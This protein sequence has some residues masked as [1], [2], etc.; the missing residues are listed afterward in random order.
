MGAEGG[1]AAVRLILDDW[2]VSVVMGGCQGGGNYVGT[3][4]TADGIAEDGG[5]GADPSVMVWG[6]PTG[7]SSV[8]R[9]SLKRSGIAFDSI[10]PQLSLV[11]TS[12]VDCRV[13]AL[14]DMLSASGALPGTCMTNGSMANRGRCKP[15]CPTA[16]LSTVEATCELGQFVWNSTCA[17]SSCDATDPTLASPCKNDGKCWIYDVARR[18]DH[19]SIWVTDPVVSSEQVACE[20]GSDWVGTYCEIPAV[21]QTILG[22]PRCQN[23]GVCS[24]KAQAAGDQLSRDFSCACAPGWGGSTCE[25]RTHAYHHLLTTPSRIPLVLLGIS[26]LCALVVV[27]PIAVRRHRRRLQQ[28]SPVWQGQAAYTDLGDGIDTDQSFLDSASIST[29][30]LAHDGSTSRL[31]CGRSSQ[32]WLQASFGCALGVASLLAGG[33]LCLALAADER[34]LPFVL[35]C[36]A[37]TYIATTITTIYMGY[38]TLA[39]IAEMEGNHVQHDWWSSHRVSVALLLLL[40]ANRIE[41]LCAV[42]QISTCGR[43]GGRPC[44]PF[45]PPHV[46]FLWS[47]GCYRL[48]S[49]DVPLLFV[50]ILVCMGW[51]DTGTADPAHHAETPADVG[52]N[53]SEACALVSLVVTCLNLLCGLLRILRQWHVRWTRRVSMAVRCP[54]LPRAHPSACPSLG[55]QI[56]L[57]RGLKLS[58][59]QPGFCCAAP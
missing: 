7:T 41:S 52:G 32:H 57:Q 11:P 19:K 6:S 51:P 34:S 20:C 28:L 16:S 49:A 23:G 15:A 38:V 30:L 17:S 8:L 31:P 1:G 4:P 47:A 40:S 46:S 44:F 39:H 33:A 43:R 29:G 53:G 26:A 54:S 42:Q 36:A 45:E 58:R 55:V 3:L 48:L 2:L 27:L 35:W 18:R 9:G 22:Q 13:Q 5:G 25:Q 50:A 24:R 21:C 59:A 14:F 12:E 10:W 37:S 56:E